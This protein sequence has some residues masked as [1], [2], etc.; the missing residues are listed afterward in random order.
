M[1]FLSCRR[2]DG[3]LLCSIT[4]FPSLVDGVFGL[5]MLHKNWSN[6]GYLGKDSHHFLTDQKPYHLLIVADMVVV[7]CVMIILEI[8]RN[9]RAN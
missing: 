1:K 5:Y 3:N 4:S 2:R 7:I 8:G 6:G 9:Y